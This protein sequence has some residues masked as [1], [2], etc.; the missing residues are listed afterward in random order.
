MEDEF[1][2]DIDFA[3]V[4]DGHGGKAVSRYLR[5]NL[6]A[7]IQAALPMI[8]K[9]R[10]IFS[11]VEESENSETGIPAANCLRHNNDEAHFSLK[12]DDTQLD[13]EPLPHAPSNGSPTVE[14]YEAAMEVALDKIDREVLRIGHWSFQGSTSVACWIHQDNESTEDPPEDVGMSTTLQYVTPRR[15]LVTANVGDSR[16]VMSRNGTAINLTR[17][18]KPCDPVELKRIYQ[19]GGKV[20]WDG[21][22]DRHGDPIPGTGIYRV[23]G[24]LALS[25]AIGDRSERPAVSAEPE[26]SVLPLTNDDE[27]VVLATDGLWDV[28]SSSDTV[29]FIHALLESDDALDKSTVAGLLVE[30]AL[31]RGTYDNVTVLI[32]WLNARTG[33]KGPKK[34]WI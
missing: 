8:L 17:D 32:I 33:P 16:A 22:I 14:D 31:R 19:F 7:N 23:N 15:T 27:F 10:P 28:M 5:Q 20:L 1:A 3:A 29:A 9:A 30:E 4:F 6:Y 25:R 24:N 26:F 18:H 13:K 21:E 11:N 12:D 34:W 2:T